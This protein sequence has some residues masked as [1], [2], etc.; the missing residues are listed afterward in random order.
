MGCDTICSTLGK[1]PRKAKV[2]CTRVLDLLAGPHI[3]ISNE[4]YNEPIGK[5]LRE[6]THNYH[7]V[8]HTGL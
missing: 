4:G 2:A 1:N 6:Y 7:S 5:E 8:P 3:Q